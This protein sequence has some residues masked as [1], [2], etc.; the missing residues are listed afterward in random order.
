[1]QTKCNNLIVKQNNLLLIQSEND[2]K[3]LLDLVIRTY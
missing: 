1:M 3:Q 2:S